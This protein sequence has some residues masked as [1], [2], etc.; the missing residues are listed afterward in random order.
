MLFRSMLVLCGQLLSRYYKEKKEKRSFSDVSE[1]AQ[2]M[3]NEFV[4]EKVEKVMLLSLNSRSQMINLSVVHKGTLTSSE[5]NVRELVQTALRY[6]ATSIVIAHNHPAGY[7]APS[8]QDVETTRALISACQ[9]LDIKLLDHVIYAAD[10]VFSMRNS[11]YHAAM[12]SQTAW[13]MERTFKEN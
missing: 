9:M 4:N 13:R 10:G 8:V 11:P 3:K 2:F 1:I 5:A 7:S 12:F 6:R